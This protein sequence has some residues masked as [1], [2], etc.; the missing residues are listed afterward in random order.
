MGLK[1]AKHQLGTLIK[2]KEHTEFAN[3]WQSLT[4]ICIQQINGYEPYLGTLQSLPRRAKWL[5]WQDQ[6]WKLSGGTI[7]PCYMLGKTANRMG[8][9]GS[10]GRRGQLG[11][12]FHFLPVSASVVAWFSSNRW[13][14]Q[15][16]SVLPQ[17]HPQ[18]LCNVQQAKPTINPTVNIHFNKSYFKFDWFLLYV[19]WPT[20]PRICPSVGKQWLLG[21][22]LAVSST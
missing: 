14:L 2:H 21:G 17:W 5:S 22:M 11:G 1:T 19:L 8:G 6:K 16:V 15:V 18:C 3:I 13:L 20:T 4:C 7:T 9:G 10:L 12:S